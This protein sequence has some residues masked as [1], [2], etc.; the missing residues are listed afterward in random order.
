MWDGRFAQ[1]K[2][3]SMYQTHDLF[4]NDLLILDIIE[5]GMELIHIIEMLDELINGIDMVSTHDDIHDDDNDFLVLLAGLL[6][7]IGLNTSF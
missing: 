5:L 1:G 4:K 7:V 2:K 3:T 6:G